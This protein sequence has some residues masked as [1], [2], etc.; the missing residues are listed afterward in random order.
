[1]TIRRFFLFLLPAVLIPTVYASDG[2]TSVYPVGVETVM[3]GLM[4]PPGKTIFEQFDNFY[5]ANGV[6]DGSGHSVVP[7]FHLRVGAFAVKVVHNWGV[8]ALGGTLISS[9][10]LPVLYL[11][12]DGP[13]GSLHKSGLGNPDIGLMA[14]AYGKGSWHWWYGVDTYVPGAP[15]NK[16]DILN[17]GQH[18]SAVAPDGAFTWLPRHGKSEISSKFQYIV[19]F[20]NPATE[21]RSGRELTWE[22]AAM[23]NV[24]KAFS[25]GV[26]GY[27]Y[28]QTSND[29]LNGLSVPGGDRGRVFAAGPQ[30]K[31]HVGRTEL[32]L[33]YQKE[34]LVANRTRGNSVWVQIGVPLWRPEH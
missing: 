10:A 25:I 15:Y 9:A 14:V 30:L 29:L 18:N 19:N 6:M 17:V 1:M 5:Q 7:G 13:F 23:Q 28:Q 34:T 26:N 20:T 8:K 2:G 31:Y 27:Y 11:H 16:D 33:K 4:P 3:P 32:I 24:T 21:Y 12:L 22:Y